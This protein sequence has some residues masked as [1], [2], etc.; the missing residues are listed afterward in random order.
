[1]FQIIAKQKNEGYYLLDWVAWHKAIGIKFVINDCS[2]HSIELLDALSL[3]INLV[4]SDVTEE[5]LGKRSVGRELCRC[6]NEIIQTTLHLILILT[7]LY[8]SEVTKL[9]LVTL[10]DITAIPAILSIG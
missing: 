2:D 9:H 6:I 3:E 7:N 10:M 5:T 8:R 4:N 1:M